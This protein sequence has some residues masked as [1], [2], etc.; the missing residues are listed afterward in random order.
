MENITEKIVSCLAHV[1]ILGPV[2][3][4]SRILYLRIHLLAKIYLQFQTQHS[5]CFGGRVHTGKKRELPHVHV[6]S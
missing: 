5:R 6:P 1:D 3:R 2:I 4:Y